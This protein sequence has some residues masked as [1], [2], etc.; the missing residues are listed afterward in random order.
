MKNVKVQNTVY[1]YYV[2]IILLSSNYF[3][4]LVIF[5]LQLQSKFNFNDPWVG[6]SDFSGISHFPILFQNQVFLVSF[7]F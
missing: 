5:E 2:Y 4:S 6:I 1:H 3:M 7:I